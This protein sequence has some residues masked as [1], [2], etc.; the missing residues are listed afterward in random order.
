VSSFVGSPGRAK[1]IGIHAPPLGPFPDWSDADLRRGEKTYKP[2]E[3]SR[4]R[5]PDGHIRQLDRHSITAIRPKDAPYG[6]E[7]IY[8]SIARNRDWFIREVGRSAS[9]VRMVL[10]GHNHRFGLLV[11]YP[12][13]DD[14]ESR[15]MKSVTLDEVRGARAGM[16]AVRREAGRVRAFPSPL[17]VN[18]TSAGPRGN[19]FGDRWRAVAPG[20]G[21]VTLAADGTIESVSPRQLALPAA[22]TPRPPAPTREPARAGR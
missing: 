5:R 17:Y 15:L 20:W 1:L 3:N 14:R 11:A 8:G 2:G 19:L 21:L 22:V 12:P 16:A 13:T 4:M 6:V 7:A 10:S 18:T 9:G